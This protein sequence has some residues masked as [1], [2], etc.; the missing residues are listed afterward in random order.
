MQVFLNCWET[1]CSCRRCARPATA[2]T[3]LSAAENDGRSWLWHLFTFCK[4]QQNIRLAENTTCEHSHQPDHE[5]I[6][7]PGQPQN[8]V[9]WVFADEETVTIFANTRQVDV[10]NYTVIVELVNCTRPGK[11]GRCLPRS[12]ASSHWVHSRLYRRYSYYIEKVLVIMG[13]LRWN[14]N[15]NHGMVNGAMGVMRHWV[16]SPGAWRAAAIHVR[17]VW[18]P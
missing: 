11:Q 2:A 10:Y 14:T 6:R 9:D 5:S 7:N 13:D 15:M 12:Q 18:R 16:A 17:G 3:A 4:L 1:W 8:P